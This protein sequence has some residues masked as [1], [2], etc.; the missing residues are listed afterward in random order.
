MKLRLYDTVQF[1][2]MVETNWT[3]IRFNQIKL[4]DGS[5]EFKILKPRY[6]VEEGSFEKV[7][8]VGNPIF[9]LPTM[10]KSLE[11]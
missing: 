3:W 5:I 10:F 7:K 11:S 1:R 4:I 9:E 6:E 2:V 8:K